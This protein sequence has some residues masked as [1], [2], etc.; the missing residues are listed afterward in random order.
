[1]NF[2]QKIEFTW[3]RSNESACLRLSLFLFRVPHF[4]NL[5]VFSASRP[6]ERLILLQ[7]R[8]S[9]MKDHVAGSRV[10]HGQEVSGRTIRILLNA[11]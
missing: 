10:D 4:R 1:M 8:T 5:S 6:K 3:V 11:R 9:E 2:L 7:N